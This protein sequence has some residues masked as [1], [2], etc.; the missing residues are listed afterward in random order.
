M[1]FIDIRGY[2]H[3]IGHQFK[4]VSFVYKTYIKDEYETV[5][6]FKKYFLPNYFSIDQ[7]NEMN[8]A[9]KMGSMDAGEGSIL[10]WDPSWQQ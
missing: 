1:V 7:F 3:I 9:H 10:L 6:P 2:W 4:E 8:T 5:T